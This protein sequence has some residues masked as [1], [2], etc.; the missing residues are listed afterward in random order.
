M[1]AVEKPFCVDDGF[2]CRVNGVVLG[3]FALR[4]RKYVEGFGDI[5]PTADEDVIVERSRKLL[6]GLGHPR[7]YKPMVIASYLVKPLAVAVGVEEARVRLLTLTPELSDNLGVNQSTLKT[8]IFTLDGKGICHKVYLAAKIPPPEF[9]I[10]DIETRLATIPKNLDVS[11]T[12]RHK[13]RILSKPIDSFEVVTNK[14]WRE[15]YIG[16]YNEYLKFVSS[17]II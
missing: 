1:S 10:A 14:I 2:T 5:V 7:H 12:V 17:K 3:P 6:N 15:A 8:A 11:T 9:D 13:M 4:V 16:E